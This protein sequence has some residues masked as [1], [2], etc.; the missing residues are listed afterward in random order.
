VAENGALADAWKRFVTDPDIL[1]V[2]VPGEPTQSRDKKQVG[3]F[4]IETRSFSVRDGAATFQVQLTEIPGDVRAL[5]SASDQLEKVLRLAP[6]ALGLPEQA[7]TRTTFAGGPSLYFRG[8][9]RDGLEVE[10]HI[11]ILGRW[12]IALGVSWP[13][14]LP[15]P[16]RVDRLFGSFE[17]R[18]RETWELSANLPPPEWRRRT[19]EGRA[20]SYEAPGDVRV[21]H[22]GTDHR[23][24]GSGDGRGNHYFVA[25]LPA[26]SSSDCI[27]DRMISAILGIEKTVMTETRFAGREGVAIRGSNKMGIMAEA[28]AA[29]FEDR[30]L[31]AAVAWPARK[32]STANEERFFNSIELGPTLGGAPPNSRA[33]RFGQWFAR[34]LGLTVLCVIVAFLIRKAWPNLLRARR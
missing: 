9:N 30:V 27:P 8:R 3:R 12:Q 20:F 33:Y 13:E 24:L 2:E 32:A 1:S 29:C 26:A 22:F 18:T 6:D 23:V 16:P 19:F 28:R 4:D 15:R 11:F 21:E 5:L 17:P 7:V 14:A 25:L 31:V 34:A 10:Q